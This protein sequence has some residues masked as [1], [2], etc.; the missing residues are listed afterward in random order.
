MKKEDHLTQLV[1]V[2]P[3]MTILNHILSLANSTDPNMAMKTNS[4]GD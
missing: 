2:E 4:K 1:K 3:S